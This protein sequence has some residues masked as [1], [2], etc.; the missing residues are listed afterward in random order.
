M[1][2]VLCIVLALVLVLSLTAC[3]GG[4]QPAG[5]TFTVATNC[6]FEPFEYIGT[7]GL[8]YGIDMEI[9]VEFCKTKGYT[10]VIKN[11]LDFDAILS[12]VSSGYADIGMAG[13]TI[14]DKRLETNDFTDTYYNAS[15]KII[16][17]SDCTLF[18]GCKTAAEVEEVILGLAKDTKIG[19]QTG[20]TGNWYVAGDEGWGYTG[21]ANID[22]KGYDSALQ[23]VQDLK[24][25][26]IFGVVVDE[27]P[28]AALAKANTGVKVIDVPLTEEEYAFAVKKGNTALVNEFNAFLKE[29]KGNG[30]FDAIIA[31][32]FEGTGAKVGS[33]FETVG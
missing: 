11:I 28:A 33:D 32:Y 17:K 20:T 5:K 19:Y 7:D 9:A 26:N 23:G 30:T 22:P 25:G 4:K 3:G 15:Q 1:K 31:K 2:K 18:D 12:Q 27:L 14:N 13:L 8:V 29:I 10:L 24:N 6:P 21:F 16:V